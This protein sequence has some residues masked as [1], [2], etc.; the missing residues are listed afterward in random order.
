L[1]LI[2]R[3]HVTAHGIGQMVRRRRPVPPV[4]AQGIE[5]Q[6]TPEEAIRRMAIDEVIAS[7]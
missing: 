6:P 3:L 5:R 7:R 4:P 2:L 1:A